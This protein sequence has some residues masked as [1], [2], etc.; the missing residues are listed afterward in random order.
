[1][2]TS[3]IYSTQIFTKTACPPTVT[4]CPAHSTK[5]VTSVV[6]VGTTVCPESDLPKATPT[7]AVTSS[8]PVS[9]VVQTYTETLIYTVGV[10]STAHPVTTEVTSTSTS[11]Q[12]STVVITV[13]KPTPT[14]EVPADATGPAGG[15]N[16]YP[17]GPAGGE[18]V[19]PKGGEDVTSTIKSTSTS[20]KYI[21][22]KPTPTGEGDVPADSES[23][24]SGPAGGN[25]AYPTGNATPSVPAGS[26]GGEDCAAP[27]T[28]TVTAKETVTVT[29]GGDYPAA[30]PNSPEETPEV[31]SEHTASSGMPSVPT[32]MYPVPGNGTNPYPAGPT[33]FKTSTKPAMP[34]GTGYVPATSVLP[35]FTFV[36]EAATPTGETA[37][38]SSTVPAGAESSAAYPVGGG[39]GDVSSKVPEASEAV[40]SS[41]VY[42]VPSA[43]PT[44]DNSYGAGSD[45]GSG[46]GTY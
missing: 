44:P 17:T 45:Y 23:N 13:G 28:V 26:E 1:M 46:Y 10:G 14:G 37:I 11:T 31:P 29:K 39:Y 32:G 5:L 27:V 38:P 18:N 24:P 22:V 34:T 8:Y 43:T 35:S 2:V 15:E 33:G 12:Y 3:T 25:G 7:K 40:S 16:A 20:T 42:V 9:E 41:A 6:A 21:T 30:T 19:Y 36:S 4:D